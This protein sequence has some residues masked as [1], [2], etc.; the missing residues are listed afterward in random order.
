[1]ITKNILQS[2]IS[3]L[4]FAAICITLTGCQQI[5]QSSIAQTNN[6]NQAVV[7]T[8]SPNSN[9]ADNA[10]AANVND[11]KISRSVS[12]SYTGDLSIFESPERDKN[13]QISRVMDILKIQPG[14][15]V[16]DIGAGSGWFTTRA[17]KRIG[18]NGTVYAVEINQEYLDY[19]TERAKR[20]NFP[21]IKTVLGT[22]DNPKLSDNSIDATLILKSYHEIAQPV[23]VLVNLRKSMKPNGLLGIIERNGDGADHGINQDVVVK[24]AK[25]AGFEFVKSYDFVKPDGQDYFAVFRLKK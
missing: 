5:E 15:N 25:K 20:E 10:N 1:M 23:K 14:S 21:N 7:T 19:I 6:S 17:A 3:A 24:E 4:A 22:E 9:N 13:L 11:D 8:A 16:A 12:E 18:S 2:R